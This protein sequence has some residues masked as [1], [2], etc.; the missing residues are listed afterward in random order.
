MAQSEETGVIRFGVFEVE[1]QTG[2]LRKH[3][4]RVRLQELPFR[5]LL[6]LIEKRGDV[7][8]RE[9]LRE[10]IWAGTAFGDFDH[11]LNIAINK[12]REALGDSAENPRFVETLPRHGY[13]FLAP[14]EGGDTSGAQAPTVAVAKARI[15]RWLPLAGAGLAAVALMAGV[16]VWMPLASPRLE[17][18]RLTNDTSLKLG[19]VLSDGARLYFRRST[20]AAATPLQILQVPVSGGTPT[21]LP[22]AVPPSPAY[23][24]LDIAP[25]GQEL[26]LSLF[27]YQFTDF[28]LRDD[29]RYLETGPLW[30]SRIVGGA[31]RRLGSLLARDARYSPDGRRIA[32]TAGAIE[33]PGSLWVASA[34]GSNARQ[35]LE[36][37][38]L[39]I[40]LPCWSADGKQIAFGQIDRATQQRSAW[41]IGVYGTRLRRLVPDFHR[42]HLPAGWTPDGGLLV[43]SEGQFWIAQ[44]RRFFWFKRPPPIQL[45]TGDP[46]FTVPIQFQR[47]GTFYSVGK[48]QLGQLQ[49]FDMRSQSWEPYLGGISVEFAEYSRD[50]QRVQ[51]TTHPERE[52]WV[53]RADGSQAV[54]L[55]KAPM[56]V[57][58]GHWSPDGRVIAL[59]AR[60]APD[61]PW[62]I[63]LVDA[64][65]GDV[66]PAC[67][68]NCVGF[69]FTWMP[70]GK[71]IVFAAPIGIF[72]TE[73]AYLR[74]L[75]LAN[76]EVTKFP[77]SDGLHSP[78]VSP[79]GSTLAA[80]GYGGAGGLAVFRFADGAWKK[81]P[82]PGPG[83]P[84]WPFWS[85]DSQFIWYYNYTR[86]EIMRVCLR[87]KRH[88]VIAPLKVE[89]MTGLIGSSFYLTPQDEPVIL[90]R[91]DV[92]QVYSLE[93]KAR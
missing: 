68:R 61:Q 62:R 36:L 27:G 28:D 51:Y 24:V 23:Q 48:T 64:A 83:G 69:D 12:I 10:K 4:V 50:G 26:L 22:I 49:H 54:Q 25:D 80:L 17:W 8:T 29:I 58:A 46:M 82:H 31:S 79:D 70:D 14:V 65:G 39:D 53:R 67:V 5:V 77:G 40:V 20:V 74:L 11:S 72:A 57:G 91:H 66:R 90:R 73:P 92:Q 6:A 93:L 38:G 52:L 81:L 45:S 71:R 42:N 3:G 88:E 44:P 32:F 15:P 18:R 75:N 13:R 19:P 87:D 76:G 63:Y 1:P 60:N 47:N 84:D 21:S 16:V 56:Q 33:S 86:E 89:E 59:C 2:R 43:I 7:L 55:T 9:E 34:D 30:T 41:A 78:R 37:K 35:I 85:R